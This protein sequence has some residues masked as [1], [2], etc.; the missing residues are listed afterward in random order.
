MM[1]LTVVSVCLLALSVVSILLNSLC[2]YIK[3]QTPSLS[4]T[5]SSILI[6]NLLCIHL[7]QGIVV[8]PLY[9]GKKL[10]VSHT[11]WARFFANGFRFSYMLSFY[12]NC[13]GVLSISVDR[14][15]AVVL[16]N[17]YKVYVS[18]RNIKRFLHFVAFYVLLLC[19]VPFFHAHYS[20]H[21][22]QTGILQNVTSEWS[23]QNETGVVRLYYYEPSD[24]WTIFMLCVNCALPYLV[25]VSCYVF[26]LH[27]LN[28]MN[29]T[30]T[31]KHD[32]MEL[33][34]R[35]TDHQ[36]TTDH[37]TNSI[38]VT[39]TNEERNRSKQILKITILVTI[40]YGVCWTPSIVYYL[41]MDICAT[42]FPLHYRTS[43]HEEYVS[44]LVKFL[45]FL[46]STLT[47]SIYCFRHNEFRSSLKRIFRYVGSTLHSEDES[48][49]VGSKGYRSKTTL[50]CSSVT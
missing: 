50:L 25:V 41:L 48:T 4:K 14:L 32:T 29:Q 37:R 13:L 28:S 16:L 44:F 22:Q 18:R 45:A 31:R 47:P 21:I 34:Q 23:L 12:G 5:A 9:V 15:L 11:F 33:V 17:H 10:K 3:K 43:S 27:R 30:F 39:S 46:N 38:D 19:I 40:I 7:F 6:T 8:F 1:D 49:S 26:I 36:P 20:N 24:A 42:C 35:N 2:L